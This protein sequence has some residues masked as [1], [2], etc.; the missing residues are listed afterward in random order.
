MNIPY[1]KNF[2]L[3][4]KKPKNVAHMNGKNGRKNSVELFKSFFDHQSRQLQL[5]PL[6]GLY[7]NNWMHQL[8]HT[9]TIMTLPIFVDVA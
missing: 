5:F 2:N 3:Y 1:L 9:Q 4:K 6:L 8:L 7:A